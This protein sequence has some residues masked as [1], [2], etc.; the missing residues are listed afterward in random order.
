MINGQLHWLVAC[1][2]MHLQS[3]ACRF[4]KML[5]A[6]A[7]RAARQSA[8]EGNSV[9]AEPLQLFQLFGTVGMAAGKV[10]GITSSSG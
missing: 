5:D 9:H 1:I 7:I 10:Y 3:D 6:F 8:Q 4:S 2:W